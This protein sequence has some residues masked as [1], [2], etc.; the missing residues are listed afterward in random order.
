THAARTGD[1]GYFRVLS[2]SG[3]AA[4]VRRIEAAT[5]WNAITAARRVTEE[6]TRTAELLK[7]PPLSTFDK[8]ERLLDQQRT[9]QREIDTLKKRL[10]SGGAGADPASDAR[11]IGGVKVLGFQVELGDAKTLRELA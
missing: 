6:L 1:I 8:A 3:L 9:L 7:T 4:G 11:D 5:G 10:A 2:D